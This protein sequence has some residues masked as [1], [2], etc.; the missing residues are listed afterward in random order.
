MALTL[1]PN[2]PDENTLAVSYMDAGLESSAGV[3]LPS[4]LWSVMYY[5][6]A[7]ATIALMRWLIDHT[8]NIYLPL[9][10]NPNQTAI[11]G[12]DPYRF[13]V[14]WRGQPLIAIINV[15]AMTV[16]FRWRTDGQP[17]PTEQAMDDRP[18]E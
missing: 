11:V 13:T 15:D 5:M 1:T 18:A 6:D 4:G 2:T 17:I 16:E 9:G 8:R 7:A 14:N 10:E 3:T 12:G